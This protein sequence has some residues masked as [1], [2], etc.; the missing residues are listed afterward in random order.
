MLE[1]LVEEGPVGQPGERIEER[2]SPQLLLELTLSG[3]V[4]QIALE[5]ERLAGI[6]EHDDAVVANP[7]DAAVACD[8]AVLET[9]R[10]VRSMGAGVCREHAIAIVRMQ[11]SDEEVRIVAP[12]LDRVA[13]QR[14]DLATRE[15]VRAAFVQGVHV[16]HERQLFDERAVTPL[17]LPSLDV[18]RRSGGRGIRA[19]LHQTEIGPNPLVAV[20]P[21]GDLRLKKSRFRARL[22]FCLLIPRHPRLERICPPSAQLP[23]FA[24]ASIRSRRV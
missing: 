4:Q 23:R 9:Q 12:L 7:D 6:V 20:T 11:R 16:D 3:D 2:L 10:L 1:L 19:A 5:V 14:L 18:P 24:S 13:E 17:D 15:D 8:E 21:K 22:D